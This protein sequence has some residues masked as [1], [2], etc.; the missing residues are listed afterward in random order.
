MA[1]GNE[2]VAKFYCTKHSWRGKSGKNSVQ[3][4]SGGDAGDGKEDAG[5]GAGRGSSPP[6]PP[7]L[8][9]HRFQ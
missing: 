1:Q 7:H 2:D 6:A 4:L 3:T 8:P 9:L 5:P